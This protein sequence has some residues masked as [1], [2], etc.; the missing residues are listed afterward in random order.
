[1]ILGAVLLENRAFDEMK[2]A[3]RPK[4]FSL[5]SHQRIAATMGRLAKNDRAIDLVTLAEQLNA[6]KDLQPIGGVAYL[7]SLTEGLPRRPVIE[8]YIRIVKD[9]SRLRS[10]I[11]ACSA[12]I[13]RA[14]EQSET[15][16]DIATDLHAQIE[17]IG[18]A[19]GEADNAQVALFLGE[20]MD[21]LNTEYRQK[22]SP[23]IPSG[24]SWFDAKTGGGYR[25]G[26]ITLVCARPNV[27]KTPWATMSTAY[28]C[29]MGRKCVFFSLEMEKDEILKN[30]IPFAVDIP[31][32]V[33]N[34][35]WVQTPDQNRLVNQG[36]EVVADWPLS[37]YDGDLDADRICWIIDRET[38]KG[39]EVL[40]CLDHFGLI[41]GGG[42]DVRTRYNENSGRIRKKI[43]HKRAAM[44]VLCQLRKVSRD[45]ADKPPVPDDVKESGNMWED[46]F[47][48]L[49]IHRPYDKDTLKMSTSADLN[50]AKLRTGGST[51]STTG[52]FDTRR[53]CFEAA[54][55]ID[56]ENYY[57]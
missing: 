52:H 16:L 1:M 18:E 3:L 25:H 32:V 46:A 2:L 9:K 39:E 47:A 55:E 33:V 42:S 14:A 28:N 50:L 19:S 21:R 31:N 22:V 13:A 45:Y 11:L 51:G 27:G 6:Q 56:F 23:A 40:F 4:D 35:P 17:T 48:G 43:K 12:A 26:K 49:L 38:R 57:A 44:V 54:A 15:A 53:L 24:N 20:A 37:V 10:I 34:R 29:R 41:S 5:D 30:L 36:A 8:E 7:S